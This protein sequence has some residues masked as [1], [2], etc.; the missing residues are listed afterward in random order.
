AFP[1]AFVEEI[2]RLKAADL[3]EVGGK[4]LT[5]VRDVVTEVVRLDTQLGLEHVEP[6]NGY[7]RL[8]IVNVGGRQVGVIVEEVVRKDEIVIK[9]LGEYMRNV[10]LFPGA[11]IAPDGSLILL[12]DLNRLIVGEAIERRPLMAGAHSAAARIFAPGA[13]A[14]AHGAIPAEAIDV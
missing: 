13:A 5:R 2:R 10:K 8:V 14:V 11:T 7:Y 4:L 6:M 9:N 12:I 1:L 3:E